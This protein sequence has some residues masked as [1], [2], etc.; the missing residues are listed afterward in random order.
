[1]SNENRKWIDF[2]YREFCKFGCSNEEM[3][4]IMLVNLLK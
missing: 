4:N 2:I 1:M 3:G